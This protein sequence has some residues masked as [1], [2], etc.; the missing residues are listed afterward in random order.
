VSAVLGRRLE[1]PAPLAPL[2]GG[3]RA[4]LPALAREIAVRYQV[5]APVAGRLTRLYGSETF[6]MLG[7]QPTPLSPSV[8][9]EEVRWAVEVEGADTLEDVVYRRLRAAWY[10]PNEC[11][12]LLERAAELMGEL[13]GWDAARRTRELAATGA[14]LAAERAFV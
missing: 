7:D 13:L 11:E 4:D 9:R 3:E 8:F 12:D 1:M 5:D 6:A 10:L 2:P 14:R